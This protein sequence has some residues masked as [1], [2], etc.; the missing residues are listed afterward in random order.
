MWFTRTR[1]A[2]STGTAIMTIQA[3]W[4]NFTTAITMRMTKRRDRNLLR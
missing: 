1:I 4:L 2:T 3:P